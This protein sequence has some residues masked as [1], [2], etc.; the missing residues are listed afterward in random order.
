MSDSLSRQLARYIASM[1]Y[2]E[3]PPVVVDRLKSLALHNLVMAMD[4]ADTP[5]GKAVVELVKREE[6]QEDGATILVDGSKA[7]R[8]G[9]AFANSQLMHVG[10][11]GDSY[12]MLSHPGGHVVS[13]ALVTAEL[14]GVSGAA[15]LTALAA[16]YE[17]HVR[18]AGSFVPATQARGFRA[19]P[20]FGIFGAVMATGKLLGLTEDQL[21]AAIALAAT[22]AGGAL[23]G[24]RVRGQETQYHDAN[25]TRNGVMAALLAQGDIRGSETA[26]EGDT[27]F[28][29]AFIGNNGGELAY[30]FTGPSTVDMAQVTD[31]LGERYEFLNVIPKIYPGKGP[32]NPV[33]EL[34]A[35]LRTKHNVDARQVEEITVEMNWL[36]THYPSPAHPSTRQFQGEGTAYQ[37]AYACVT[38]GFP[39]VR[40]RRG[41]G[42]SPAQEDPLIAELMEQVTVVPQEDWGTYAPRI[43]IVMKDGARYQGQYTGDELKYDLA[44]ETRRIREVFPHLP[45]PASQLEELSS[46]VAELQG[47]DTIEPLVQL[48]VVR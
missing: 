46:C 2:E 1:S 38:G 17:A 18:I 42:A 45:A 41:P 10:V 7:T 37:A 48:C 28:Y 36:E 35:E 27:G 21:V 6:A 32:D 19:S 30:V 3:L 26:L 11:H 9:A 14:A 43:T 13:A 25:A 23:E 29:N 12:L 40:E 24:A 8:V 33:I 31:G 47:A 20:A 39:R 4:G 44:T 16:G 15:F 5:S 22:F 34:M